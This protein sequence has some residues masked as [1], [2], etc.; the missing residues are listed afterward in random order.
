MESENEPLFSIR[1]LLET[2]TVPRVSRD[3]NSTFFTRIGDGHH[4]N[5]VTLRF[6][7][8]ACTLN[9]YVTCTN[10]HTN[11]NT[12]MAFIDFPTSQQPINKNHWKKKQNP[13]ESQ[14]PMSRERLGISVVKSDLKLCLMTPQQGHTALPSARSNRRTK[15]RRTSGIFRRFFGRKKKE[16]K[17]NMC[18]EKE[19]FIEESYI[20]TL[21]EIWWDMYTRCFLKLPI[22]WEKLSSALVTILP[23]I[24]IVQIKKMPQ[25]SLYHLHIYTLRSYNFSL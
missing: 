4:L 15:L 20:Y 19:K 11:W 3:S 2:I 18:H 13:R 10:R 7:M 24:I 17:K 25:S 5:R 22:E 6:Y 8:Y 16:I 1:F 9:M 14:P 12:S 21:I 23:I